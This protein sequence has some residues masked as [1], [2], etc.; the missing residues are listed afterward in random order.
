MAFIQDN[1]DTILSIIN[2][3]RG[4]L[5]YELLAEEL[6]I[7]LGLKKP[8]SRHTFLKHS[9]IKFAY[10]NKKD[11]LRDKK[12]QAINEAKSLFDAS[13]KLSRLL[14]NIDDDDATI[15]ELIKCA[16]KLE[17]ENERLV[18]ENN[19]LKKQFDKVLETF[20]RWQYNLQR[21]D[22]VDLYKLEEKLNE[23]LPAKNRD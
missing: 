9:E 5:T 15:S 1:K 12:S 8:P 16:E 2:G 7:R 20:A 23:G 18:S 10:E 3:W 19:T 11:E 6:R 17:R 22:G 21:M 13:D 4:K 14:S